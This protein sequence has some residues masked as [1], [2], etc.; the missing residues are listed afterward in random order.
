[1]L[2][3]EYLYEGATCWYYYPGDPAVPFEKSVKLAEKHFSQ[4]TNV[5]GWKNTTIVGIRPMLKK[6]ET[7]KK[8]IALTDDSAISTTRTRKS[9]SNRSDTPDAEESNSGAASTSTSPSKPEGNP[10]ATTT[11]RRKSTSALRPSSRRKKTT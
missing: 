3:I 10:K 1:M 5:S 7:Q 6:D 8:V 4:I 11:T 9:R 2:E